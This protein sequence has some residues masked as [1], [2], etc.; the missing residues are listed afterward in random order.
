MSGVVP[1]GT[2]LAAA[3]STIAIFGFGPIS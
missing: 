1:A 3:I 2:A